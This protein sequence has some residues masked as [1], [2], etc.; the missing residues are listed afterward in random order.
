MSDCKCHCGLV[1]FF[2]A[3]LMLLTGCSR[4]SDEFTGT[5][6]HPLGTISASITD[7]NRSKGI[8][9]AKLEF[10]NWN[11]TANPSDQSNNLEKGFL[12]EGNVILIE[13]GKPLNPSIVQP[14]ALAGSGDLYNY[15]ISFEVNAE[16]PTKRS[17]YELKIF[18][19]G[20]TPDTITVPLSKTV[21]R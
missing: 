20:I 2:V 3:T 9:E 7:N 19:S 16:A 4:E 11:K 6:Q 17:H 8:V 18:R 1:Y 5:V 12:N 15:F 21:E 14:Y 13:N 10:P